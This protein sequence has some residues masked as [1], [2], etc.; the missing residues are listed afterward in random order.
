MRNDP[1]PQAKR[2]GG[3]SGRGRAQLDCSLRAARSSTAAARL[4]NHPCTT[5]L[6]KHPPSYYASCYYLRAAATAKSFHLLI[7]D[8]AI[9]DHEAI[10]IADPFERRTIEPLPEQRPEVVHDRTVRRRIL[11]EALEHLRHPTIDR[12]R[13]LPQLPAIPELQATGKFHHAAGHKK[14]S[15][16]RRVR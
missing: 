10:D 8:L 5:Q 15:E 16:E 4:P 9:L 14:R 13:T 2:S 12:R 11:L 3:G 7:G 1:P 6:W